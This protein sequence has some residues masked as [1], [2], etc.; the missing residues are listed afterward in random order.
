MNSSWLLYPIFIELG[1][2]KQGLYG[3]INGV[4]ANISHSSSTIGF[5]CRTIWF[6]HSL[7][8]CTNWN[9]ENVSIFIQ[10]NKLIFTARNEVG[11]RLYFHRRLWFCP[12]GGTGMCGCWGACMVA[13][14]HVWLWGCVCGCWGGCMVAR[15]VCMVARGCAWLLG[16]MHG[17]QEGACVVAGGC[18]WLQGGMHGCQGACMFAGGVHD[19]REG[20][21]RARRDTFNERAVRI[22]LECI[23]VQVRFEV[24]RPDG[25]VGVNS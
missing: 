14:G 13:G 9:C 4:S 19:Y 3:S 2:K 6:S 7:P 22:L 18:V 10:N 12:Q 8:G 11:A 25:Q 21:C 17:C 1:S 20:M 16:G 24:T 5:C 15:G 23:L